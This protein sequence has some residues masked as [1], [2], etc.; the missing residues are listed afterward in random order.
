MRKII[1]PYRSAD[2]CF[3]HATKSIVVLVLLGLGPMTLTGFAVCAH[4][5]AR[6]NLY[7]LDH[8]IPQIGM[9]MGFL[10]QIRMSWLRALSRCYCCGPG[11]WRCELAE[12]AFNLRRGA[13]RVLALPVLSAGKAQRC[14][15]QLAKRTGAG[16][17]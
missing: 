4:T 12:R 7:A 3:K 10:L 13:G 5:F 9:A 2:R 1:Q 8:V 17:S 6:I 16:V 11:R 15:C 14:W